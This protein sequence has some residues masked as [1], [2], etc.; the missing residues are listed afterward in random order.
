MTVEASTK[1]LVK[2][3][4]GLDSSSSG[5]FLDWEGKKIIWWTDYWASFSLGENI[6]PLWTERRNLPCGFFCRKNLSLSTV[7]L[8]RSCLLSIN[9]RWSW[10]ILPSPFI[11]SATRGK[12][13]SSGVGAVAVLFVLFICGNPDLRGEV[14]KHRKGCAN[15]GGWGWVADRRSITSLLILGDAFPNPTNFWQVS[16]VG[17]KHARPVFPNN[18][19]RCALET[20]I[21]GSVTKTMP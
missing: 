16:G 9:S 18:S 14:Q 2:V 1:S 6:R 21:Q 17:P 7:G 19:S 4:A 8:P 5:T 12:V 10:K 3:I 20:P 15:C 13:V 11:T